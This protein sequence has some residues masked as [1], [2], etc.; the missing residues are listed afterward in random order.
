M[1][2]RAIHEDAIQ[3]LVSARTFARGREYFQRGAASHLM[4]RGDEL[5]AD[6]HG[7]EFAPYDVKIQFH[8]GGVAH[9]SCS[10]PYDEERYCK[11]IVAVLLK[12]ASDPDSTVE[13]PPIADLLSALDREALEGL[14]LKRLESDP[15]LA[16]WI[17][18]ELA[19]SSAGSN[20]KLLTGAHRPI[21][22]LE[23][24]R[25]QARIL[26]AG[27]YRRR[28]YWDDYRS[29]GD[30]EELRR[31]VEKAVPFL[32]AG[33]GRNALCLLEPIA[34]SF[35]DGWFEYSHDDE[36][37][38]PLFDD[39]GRLMAEA[40]LMSEPAPENR[41][42]LAGTLREWQQRLDDYGI[43]NGFH[44]AIRAL[45]EGWNEAGLPAVL[46]GDGKTW[47]LSGTA[48]FIER[49]LTGVRL[50]VLEACG[51]DQAYLNLASA[52]GHH[53]D[54]AR[55]LVKL[56]RVAEAIEFGLCGLKTSDDALSLAVALREA[57]A[58]EGALQIAETGLGLGIAGQSGWPDRSNSPLAH[59]LRD[60]AGGIGRLNLALTAACT[61][62]ECTLSMEDYR[63]VQLW[64]G[65]RWPE[66][67]PRL[68]ETLADAAY[69]HDR[70]RI[71]LSENMVDEAVRTVGK[72]GGYGAYDDTLMDLAE[73]AHASHS[74]WVIRFAHKQASRIMD[75]GNAQSYEVAA[76]WLHKAAR[77]YRASGKENQWAVALEA[78]IDQHK[79]K[80]KLRPLLEALR[81]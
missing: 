44:V 9:A 1:T 37:M 70:I 32:E 58:H 77:A 43:D 38:Y 29:S 19:V 73:A 31:L 26:L 59:W 3:A 72:E 81:H 62:F 2:G 68:L 39:L 28:R 49:E 16:R 55:F 36:E 8:D 54:Y 30:F 74:D 80:Y 11:H 63:A 15:G 18:A 17:E 60:Y 50:R 14:L 64:A 48:D 61:A 40:V 41:D 23:P 71:Y 20:A 22:D 34:E 45:E 10:C 51:R 46:A 53:A 75:A 66:I 56:G 13:R 78:L 21:I 27:R 24:I 67:R 42:D 47:P 4:R 6:V 52:A 69:A 7:S 25:E 33:D 57:G 12:F 65:E 35:V 76:G 5:S 79:R